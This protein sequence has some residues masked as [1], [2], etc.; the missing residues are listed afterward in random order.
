MALGS[1][2]SLGHTAYFLQTA[3]MLGNNSIPRCRSNA[4][5][6][7]LVSLRNVHRSALKVALS[8]A[9]WTSRV[10]CST[11]PSSPFW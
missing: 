2:P 11:S 6:W 10:G 4:K 8:Y 7:R 9:G 1:E 3:E 5:P